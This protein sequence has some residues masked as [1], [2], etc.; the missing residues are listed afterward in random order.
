MKNRNLTLLGLGITVFAIAC[1]K[2]DVPNENAAKVEQPAAI[3]AAVSNWKL[4][5]NW[6]ISSGSASTTYQ[7]RIED[8][9]I[10]TDVA[11][12]GLVLVYANNGESIESLPYEQKDGLANYSW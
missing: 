9:A 8:P 4:V 6:Q 3:T 2:M 5:N 10:T 12:D 11:T 7:S 1:K